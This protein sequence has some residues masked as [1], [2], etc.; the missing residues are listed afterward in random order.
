MCILAVIDY[1]VD[2]FRFKYDFLLWLPL[3]ASLFYFT[4]IK[5]FIS[6]IDLKVFPNHLLV[7]SQYGKA[8]DINDLVIPANSIKNI[9]PEYEYNC[10]F[11]HSTKWLPGNPGEGKW[12]GWFIYLA[13]LPVDLTAIA[14]ETTEGKYLIGCND[15]VDVAEKLNELYASQIQKEDALKLADRI[16][17]RFKGKEFEDSTTL[18]REDR[19]R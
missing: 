18:I 2:D 12:E 15:P 7:K 4:F 16:R 1:S 10:K 11:N 14:V 9:Q 6:V 5:P 17:K 19:E 8:Q 13:W 3:V